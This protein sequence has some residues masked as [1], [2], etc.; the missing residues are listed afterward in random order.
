MLPESGRV[1]VHHLSE[2]LKLFAV[3]PLNELLCLV[4]S[5]DLVCGRA[6]QTQT[7][8]DSCMRNRYYPM[9]WLFI[10]KLHSGRDLFLGQLVLLHREFV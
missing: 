4:G 5:Y 6:Y 9:E 1:L 7:F 2:L 10:I 8:G 3:R